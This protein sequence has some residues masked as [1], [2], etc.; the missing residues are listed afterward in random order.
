[1]GLINSGK[2][3]ESSEIF[4][5]LNDCKFLGTT[6]STNNDRAKEINNRPNKAEKTFYAL[7]ECPLA[8]KRRLKEQNSILYTRP[9]KKADLDVQTRG[10]GSDEHNGRKAEDFRKSN[11]EKSPRTI[12]DIQARKVGEGDVIDDCGS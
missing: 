10:L 5:N 9:Y 11:L 2:Y 1:M 7:A 12:F 4:E 3:P 6:L 8:L